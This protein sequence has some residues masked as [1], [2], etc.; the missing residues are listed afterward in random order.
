MTVK[1]FTEHIKDQICLAY[2]HK[3]MKQWEL[4]KHF[5]TSPRTIGRVLED[6]GLATPVPRLKGEAY[7]TMQILAEYGL[8]P[9]TLRHTLDL[10]AL[11]PENVQRFL[12]SSTQEELAT[13]FYTSGL[14]KLADTPQ[15][16]NVDPEPTET[17][18]LSSTY[19]GF[20]YSGQSAGGH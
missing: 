7:M 15:Q 2:A 4:A 3:T 8:T 20:P 10:P 12:N 19:A 13:Y 1:C 14:A 6:R 18:N 5:E 16:I 17:T 11:T 9:E